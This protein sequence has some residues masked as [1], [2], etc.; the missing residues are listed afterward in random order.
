MNKPSITPFH[1]LT[2]WVTLLAFVFTTLPAHATLSIA[3][4]RIIFNLY[5]G[6]GRLI[7][8]TDA[9]GKTTAFA[10]NVGGRI[11]TI[12]DRAGNVTRHAYDDFGNVTRTD[13]PDGSSVAMTYHHWSDGRPGD[14]KTSETV[15]G[16]FYDETGAPQVR[17]FTTTYDYE[18]P[19]VPPKDDGLLRHVTDPLGHTTSFTYDPSGSPLT[20]TDARGRMTQMDYDNAGNLISTTDAL[21]HST[22]YSYDAGGNRTSE[23]TSVTVADAAGAVRVDTIASSYSFDAQGHMTSMTDAKG[24]MTNFDYDP[25]GNQLRARTTRTLA[26]GAVVDVVR[27][28]QFDDENRVIASWDAEHPRALFANAPTSRTVFN[29]I[30]K[31]WK[32]YDAL[33][34][35]SE[36]LY[37]D[38][39]ALT[40]MSYA[41]GTSTQT[42]YDDEGRRQYSR[43][44]RGMWTQTYYDATGRVTGSVFLGDSS[45]PPVTLGMSEYD[46]A[47]RVWRSTDTN[48]HASRSVFDDA[49]RR[50]AV[51]D[52]LGRI[53]RYAYDENG[54]QLAF[55]DAKG[56][57]TTFAY[58]DLNRRTATTLP[59]AALDADGNGTIDAG[60]ASVVTNMSVSYDEMGR[61]V[62]E[63]DANGHTKRFVYDSLGRLNAVVD[64]LG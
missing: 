41:D 3:S 26:S 2:T 63:T 27:E 22:G 33:G 18:N 8:T 11:E 25:K 32:T 44:R 31:P 39:G 47:G 36:M 5:D 35:V 60:E 21:G 6:D 29:E 37:D 19:G 55:Q 1:R 64:A 20:I 23:S 14:L 59:A 24:H 34:H 40:A 15:S 38:R 46:G 9:N 49:G 57:V 53:S 16:T 56:R 51:V 62:S 61:R 4:K 58:D 52:A 48:G 10:H 50:T 42:T 17:S 28:S 30:S 45:Q 7:S 13:R 12:T 54:N 43:D